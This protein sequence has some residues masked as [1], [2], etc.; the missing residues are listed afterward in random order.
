MH[1]WLLS[2]L[3]ASLL[4]HAASAAPAE[5]K[6]LLDSMDQVTFAAS[7][8]KGHVER[9]PGRDG[10]ALKFSF[11]NDCAG[12]FIQG[13][14]PGGPEW[15][16]AA[17]FSFWVKGDGSE[18]LG[19]IEFIWNGDYS[20]RYAYAFPIN[21]TQ[22]KKVVVPWRDL[23]PE[24]SGIAQA[25]DPHGDHP[26]SKLGP[27]VFGKWWYWKDYAAH[28]YTV[29]DIRLEPSIVQDERQYRPLGAPLARVRAKL[30]AG[31]PI[32][33]VTMG[34]SL[35]DFA[36]WT[37][38]Q[39]NW[40]TLLAAQITKTHGSPVTLVNPALGGTELRQNLILLPRWTTGT[41]R[42]DLVTIFFGFNDYSVGMRQARFT[43]T[44]QDAI[45]RVRRATGGR[46][47]VLIMT[48]CPPLT[49][50]NGEALGELAEA[51]RQAARSRNA[52]LCDIYAVFQA[53]PLAERPALHA[54][55]GVHL[56]LA[57]QQLVAQ[58]VM[59]ALEN[60]GR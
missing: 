34:D 13:R 39:T 56:S 29:D 26:P 24:T 55:D 22:W 20:Q 27:L 25:I 45:D 46:A 35:T 16:R 44:L 18:H 10:G 60:A 14:H 8:P 41:P 2:I 23:I 59:K 57:G 54:P 30:K 11:D 53:V 42:P 37:N 5:D 38:R 58:T 3:L 28:S 43:Q 6:T 49:L 48:T 17:G 19:G 1:K 21:S 32:T 12:V 33:L 15:D 40:P 4:C 9:V 36:H 51:C 31:K 50:N 47:D 52:G 7:S